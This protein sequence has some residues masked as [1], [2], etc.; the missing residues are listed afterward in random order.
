RLYVDYRLL[1]KF[2]V[3]DWYSLPRIEDLLVRVSVSNYF[4]TL[5]L[6]SGFWQGP[7]RKSDLPK[8]TFRTH[9]GLGI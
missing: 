8:T 2:S 6:R 4:T 1:N 5:D 7:M 9:R 3:A